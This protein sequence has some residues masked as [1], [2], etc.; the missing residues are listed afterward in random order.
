MVLQVVLISPLLN[1]R[2]MIRIFVP[3]LLICLYSCTPD[4]QLLKGDWHIAG[5]Y[6]DGQ[7]VA[8]KLDSV[9]LEFHPDQTYEFHSVGFYHET[10]AYRTSGR[11]LFLMDSTA[12]E[13]KERALKILFLSNDS[14]KIEMRR[15]SVEQVLF[16]A[17]KQ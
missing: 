15:D 16:F 5:Y 11:Y 9:R 17:K 3:A 8:A 10:G 12:K 2:N 4:P 6:Q 7:S 14:L 1:A 13:P